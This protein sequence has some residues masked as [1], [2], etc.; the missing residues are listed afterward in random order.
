MGFFCCFNKH[1]PICF[2]YQLASKLIPLVLNKIS[3]III[4]FTRSQ[5]SKTPSFEGALNVT[6]MK[7]K[8]LMSEQNRK[9]LMGPGLIDSFS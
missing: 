3:R 6:V 5:K 7:E 1:F 8:R 4:A 9:R 2:K